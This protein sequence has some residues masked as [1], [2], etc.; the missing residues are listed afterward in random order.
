MGYAYRPHQA[1]QL[2]S[3]FQPPALAALRPRRRR[4]RL[5]FRHFILLAGAALML[6]CLTAAPSQAGIDWSPLWRIAAEPQDGP[7][8]EYEVVGQHDYAVR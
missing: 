6:G 1:G 2:V 4:R 7:V 8:A 3:W 5:R